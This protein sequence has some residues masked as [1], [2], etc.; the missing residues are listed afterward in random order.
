VKAGKMMWKAM[1]NANW[2]RDSMSASNS[3]MPSLFDD[4]LLP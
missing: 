4:P 1:V 3:M 2:M